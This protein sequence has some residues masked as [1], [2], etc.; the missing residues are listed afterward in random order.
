MIFI[1]KNISANPIK[2]TIP[3]TL[4]IFIIVDGWLI[5]G[6]NFPV[7][8]LKFKIAIIG[9]TTKDKTV[10]KSTNVF[11]LS[12]NWKIT[13]SEPMAI[14]KRITTYNILDFI[15]SMFSFLVKSNSIVL[16]KDLE[17]PSNTAIIVPNI[18][19]KA[20]AEIMI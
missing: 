15:P 4:V 16:F 18:I 7:T 14:I 19:A 11:R 6:R 9:A 20:E 5:F 17:Y 8:S 13:T 3:A 10:A 2:N 1:I 12:P